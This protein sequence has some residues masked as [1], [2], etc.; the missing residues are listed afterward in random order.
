ERLILANTSFSP[1]GQVGSL[2][3]EQ[4]Q[5]IYNAVRRAFAECTEQPSWNPQRPIVLVREPKIRRQVRTYLAAQWPTVFVT[6]FTEMVSD[7]TLRP[8]ATAKL[9]VVRQEVAA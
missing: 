7:V 1:E 4:V 5:S 9:E 3:I 8:L 2:S 6:T